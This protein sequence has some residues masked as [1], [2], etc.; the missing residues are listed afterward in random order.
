MID[1]ITTPFSLEDLKKL[2]EAGSTSV[3]IGTPFF[4][5]RNV[6]DFSVE[7]LPLVKEECHKLGLR[8]YVLVNRFFVEEELEALREHLQRLKDLDVDGIYYGDE[9]VYQEAKALG[10]ENRLIYNPDTLITNHSDVQYYLDEG[11]SMVTI[12]KEITLDEICAIAKK[13]QGECEVII[14]GRLNMMHSKRNLLSNYFSFLGKEE[15]IRN[16]MDLYLMEEHR[17]EHMPIVEDETGTHV[18]TGFTLSSFDEIK[19]MVHAGI[20][21]FRID[22]IFHDVD[23]VIEALKL[24]QSV[25]QDE[26]KG[27]EVFEAYKK[28]YEKDHVTHGFYYT[29]TS[30]VKEG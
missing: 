20:R 23:Y 9:G 4:S 1:F 14:H 7:E 10:I 28:K 29:K 11:I 8:M 21:H 13:V 5:V 27:R 17:D 22:G 18:F 25:L 2:K 19:D 6:H 30:K 15:N 16:K 24:Y 12:S 3:V 26:V